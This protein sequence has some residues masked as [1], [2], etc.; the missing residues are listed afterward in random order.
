MISLLTLTMF[1]HVEHKYLTTNHEHFYDFNSIENNLAK[2]PK[3]SVF[4]LPSPPDI[5]T[6]VVKLN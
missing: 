6:L 4:D 2:A 1:L 3:K 5:I